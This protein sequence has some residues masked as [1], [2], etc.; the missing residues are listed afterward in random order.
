MLHVRQ[1][2]QRE[3]STALRGTDTQSDATSG[4][5]SAARIRSWP[6]CA[7]GLGRSHGRDRGGTT[8]S[9]AVCDDAKPLSG[10]FC[11]GIPIPEVG[12]LHYLPQLWPV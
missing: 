9:A 7:N 2:G 5:L 8:E 12:S 4:C 1:P 10:P 11:D 6:G 3:H